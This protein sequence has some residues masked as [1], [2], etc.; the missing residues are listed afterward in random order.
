MRTTVTL[1]ADAERLI[2]E[3][4]TEQRVSFK[5]ALNDAVV[6]GLSGPRPQVTF[7]T[8]TVALGR[9]YAPLDQALALAAELEDEEL[10]RKRSVG[11]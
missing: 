11:K 10:L 9:S 6:A 3:V 5:K 2:R 7:E 8:P 4:M 1:D